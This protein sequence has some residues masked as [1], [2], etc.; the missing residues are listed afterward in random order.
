MLIMHFTLGLNMRKQKLLEWTI[1]P[2][3]LKK[4]GIRCDGESF[5]YFTLQP[6]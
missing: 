4:H 2:I 6:N 5:K 3:V 1:E